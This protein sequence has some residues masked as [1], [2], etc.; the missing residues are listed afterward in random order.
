[1]RNISSEAACL[2]E[3][4]RI[5]TDTF[6][7][8]IIAHV[9]LLEFSH[10]SSSWVPWEHPISVEGQAV[11]YMESQKQSFIRAHINKVIS[12]QVYSDDKKKDGPH[13]MISNLK[14]LNTYIE[15]NHFKIKSTQNVIQVI[16]PSAFIGSVDL[17]G[18]FIQSQSICEQRENL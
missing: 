2:S 1:M 16:S 3:W 7:L 13:R 17:K 11:I 10:I 18:P 9:L 15:Y 5:T 14:N 8:S 4:Q 6:I 12:A